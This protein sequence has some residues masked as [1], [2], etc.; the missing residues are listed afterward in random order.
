MKKIVLLSVSAFLILTSKPALAQSTF[1]QIYQLLNS[2]TCG[3]NFNSCHNSSAPS[4]LNFNQTEQ[5]VYDELVNQIPQNNTS[6]LKNEKL[7]YPGHPYRSF[8]FRKI[9]NGLAYNVDLENGEGVNMPQS[10]PALSNKQIELIRQWIIYGA[11]YTGN[12]ANTNLI[13]EFYDNLGIESIPNPPVAPNASEGFQIHFGPIFLPPGGENLSTTGIPLMIRADMNMEDTVEFYRIEN[14]TGTGFHHSGVS[15]VNNTSEIENIPYGIITQDSLASLVAF[16][17]VKLLAAFQQNDTLI[18]PSGSAFEIPKDAPLL[19]SDHFINTSLSKVLSCDI[20][21]NIYYQPKNTALQLMKVQLWNYGTNPNNPVIELP[22]DNLLYTYQE[23]IYEPG[24]TEKRYMWGIMCHSHV[25][26][27]YHDFYLRNND[28]TNGIK[29]YEGACPNG[30]PECSTPMFQPFE[31]PTRYFNNFIE[32]DMGKGLRRQ[33]GFRNQSSDTI[34]YGGLALTNEMMG[35]AYYYISDTTGIGAPP[36]SI[37][38]NIVK[39]SSEIILYPNPFT[40]NIIIDWAELNTTSPVILSVFDITGNLCYK[41]GNITSK[42][43]TL[44]KN[45]LPASGMYL[46]TIQSAELTL[47]GKFILN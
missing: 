34:H 29:I 38:E 35:M 36:N 23:S 20:Y 25:Y 45:N 15:I 13:Q 46:F 26:T 44:S 32:F 43:I 17:D 24:S 8:L 6:A 27:I 28:N 1:N 40:Q 42:K 5:L 39:N 30:L 10:S 18:L 33:A 47:S 37:S 4:G 11:P 12:V 31:I 21:L 41:S 14:H 2:S 3:N 9:N 19:Y 7:V 22:P 16:S